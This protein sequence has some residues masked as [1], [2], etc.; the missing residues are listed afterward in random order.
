MLTE[1]CICG[2][3]E[4]M[5]EDHF[6]LPMLRCPCGVLRQAVDMTPAEY[7]DWYR[8]K[9]HD[10]VYAHSY[11]HDRTVAKKRLDA[12]RL[13]SGLS[14]LDIGSGNNAFVDEAVERGL[15]AWGAEPGE[16]FETPRTYRGVIDDLHFPPVHFDVITI[17]DVLEHAPDMR[18][19]LREV[20]RMMKRPSTLILDFP[21]FHDPAGEH[22][23]KP[24]EHLWMLDE[25]QLREL[26]RSEG[27]RVET[28]AHP[29]PSK[30]VMTATALRQP[31]PVK[32][33]VPPGIGDGYWTF[34]KLR[35]FLEEKGI[36]L[37]EVYVH[38]A[39]HHRADGFWSRVP[40]VRFGGYADLPKN[41]PA[42][43]VYKEPGHAL[44][45][46]VHGFDY[47]ISLNGDVDAGRTV[48]EGLP[49][50]AANWYEPLFQPK[51][52]YAHRDAFRERYG[53]YVACAFFEQGFYSRW[54]Q[55]FGEEKI[56][57]ALKLIADA[58]KTVVVMGAAWDAK[59]IAP[60]IAAADPR[61]VSLIG[62]TDFD[63]LTGLLDGAAGVLGFPAGNTLLGPYYRKPTLLFWE[64][65]FPPAFW[66]NTVPPDA[67]FYA[68]VDVKDATPE[69]VAQTFLGMLAGVKP[70]KLSEE[71][72]ARPRHVY[73]APA[74]QKRQIRAP[75]RPARP[76]ARTAP[77]PATRT[78]AAVSL[79]TRRSDVAG[80]ELAPGTLRISV[81]NVQAALDVL[82]VPA[83]QTEMDSHLGVLSWWP[84]DVTAARRTVS[85][86]I[87]RHAN[88]RTTFLE[89]TGPD[90]FTD[91]GNAWP[92]IIKA[93]ETL[94]EGFS[95]SAPP[96]RTPRPTRPL[97]APP[98]IQGV[99]SP[100]LLRA[101]PPIVLPPVTQPRHA[102][103]L[104]GA[105]CVWEDLRALEQLMGRPWDGI[106]IAANDI[107]AHWPGRLDH[108]VTLHPEN[109]VKWITLRREL[110]HQDG[111][112]TWTPQNK[113]PKLKGIPQP[114]THR[115]VQNFAAGASGLL[116]CVVALEKL[117]CVRGVLCGIPMTSTPHF[118]ESKSQVKG[119][120]WSAADAHWKA[121]KDAKVLA[122][123]AGRVK[124]L[125]GR[126]R[127]LLGAPDLQWLGEC[128]DCEEAA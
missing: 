115:P 49:G 126:T 48:E 55:H 101:L 71:M 59:G 81:P 40:F 68:P 32:V 46:D 30:I 34:V 26:L 94:L 113:L 128:V 58:G 15:D 104:G 78:Q 57:A 28:V 96:P 112:T 124:S 74:S 6:G 123:L 110:G 76:V 105:E 73:Q 41:D 70:P 33:L 63:A 17:H 37:P 92:V 77:R 54:I 109:F 13:A 69:S 83:K 75:V 24:T 14:L 80:M 90:V 23:W 12:Y 88:S 66:I 44:Q 100:A 1:A 45:R 107:G 64:D 51:A 53:E 11:E 27:F 19:F 89:F 79:A 125:S 47:F 86:F 50:P 4:F 127:D 16:K 118:A 85:G 84:V 3:M 119:R 21:R 82:G 56:V 20:A 102:L 38:G 62:D 106:V 10:G 117:G 61:F 72:L 95:G 2:S 116:A 43:R 36:Y 97:R 108:W 42:L 114:V 39:G 99:E 8:V 67:E 87:I 103:I 65:H 29:I 93:G 18:A 111:F 22:H 31:S 9:Y 7:A 35:G 60:R 91:A 98:K 120:K 5:R 121:W 122:K 52:H 25:A